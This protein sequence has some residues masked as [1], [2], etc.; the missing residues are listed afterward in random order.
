LIF[1]AFCVGCLWGFEPE[2]TAF[3]KSNNINQLSA[4]GLI[5]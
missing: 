2:S 1:S 4:N 3:S 5:S